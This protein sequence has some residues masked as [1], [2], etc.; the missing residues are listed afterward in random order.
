M[1]RK[2]TIVYDPSL[3]FQENVAKN[4]GRAEALRYYLKT[5]GID[6]EG[7]RQNLII[8]KIEKVKKENPDASQAAL[9]R[10]AGIGINTLK[11]YL[12]FIEGKSKVIESKR[13]RRKVK[14]LVWDQGIPTVKGD[15][16][17][18]VMSARL[19]NLPAFFQ[20]ADEEDV[21]GLHD[22]LFAHPEKPMLFV[23]N[24][25]MLDHL[26][27]LLY[28]MNSGISK[29]VT[30]LDLASMSNDTIK[31]SRFLLTSKGGLTKD[32]S[33]ALKRLIKLNPEN[34]AFYTNHFSTK[35]LDSPIKYY[36]FTK[37][38]RVG[39]PFIDVE[40][41]FY[42]YAILYR[43]FSGG[44]MSDMDVTL[45][46][47]ECYQYQLNNS[48]AKL[49]PLKRISHF[50][51]LY[52]DYGA[53]AAHDFESIVAETG[54][55]SATLSDYRNYCHGRFV[56]VSNRTRHNKP[57]HSLSESDVAV[58]LFITPRN[59]GLVASIREKA[60]AKNTPIVLIE[61]QYND[62]RAAMDLLIKANVFLAD[63]EEKGLG[64]NPCF[65]NNYSSPQ[66]DKQVPRGEIC[67][68][69][70]VKRNGPLTFPR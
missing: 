40:A 3:T 62:A 67:F 38:G 66:I 10:A 31:N 54:V 5:H 36:S 14:S 12:P 39:D 8:A 58:V 63:Y 43:A 22:F 16:D 48:A 45:F 25:G 50:V 18:G 1:P 37:R 41:K 17:H 53:P 51:L 68:E 60:I 2:S 70:E 64:V 30:P 9:A 26:G 24:G 23:G 69:N 27:P 28:E 21:S 55:A 15:E 52:S 46:S 57:K 19:S 49:T 56:F 4:G 34:T 33:Y 47:E 6:R 11:K 32:M 59:K 44:K 13:Q 42:R 7:D 61:S 29:S 35:Q 65:P 20:R